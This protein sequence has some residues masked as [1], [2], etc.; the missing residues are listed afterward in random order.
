MKYIVL[1]LYGD[2]VIFFWSKLFFF[3]INKTYDLYINKTKWESNK[4]SIL[5]CNY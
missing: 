3:W 4:L 5:K 1:N 2:Y